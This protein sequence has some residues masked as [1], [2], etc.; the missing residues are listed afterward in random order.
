MHSD[1]R[2]GKPRGIGVLLGQVHTDRCS[3]QAWEASRAVMSNRTTARRFGS[4]WVVNTPREQ[5]IYKVDANRTTLCALSSCDD[6]RVY[7]I[8]ATCASV[9]SIGTNAA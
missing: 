5:I 3:I 1:G 8:E 4:D 2:A 9:A 6:H 7:M